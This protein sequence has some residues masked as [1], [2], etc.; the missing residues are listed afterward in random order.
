[1]TARGEPFDSLALSVPK[2]ELAQDR[3]AEIRA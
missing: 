2:G 3:R 1:M